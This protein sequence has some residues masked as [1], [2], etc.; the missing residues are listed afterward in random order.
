MPIKKNW[1]KATKQQIKSKVPEKKGIYELK[2]F[3]EV[4]YVGSSSDLRRRLLEH[5]DDRNPNY[6]RFKKLG[7]FSSLKNA[8][9]EHYDRHVDKYGQPPTWNEKRP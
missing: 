6:Y 9:R 7:F 5:L 3:G 8:E 1:S 2:S 4:K